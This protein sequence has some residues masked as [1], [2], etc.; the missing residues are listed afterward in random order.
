MK[1]DKPAPADF[2]SGAEP[3]PDKAGAVS[4][5]DLETEV[6]ASP[7]AEPDGDLDIAALDAEIAADGIFEADGVLEPEPAPEPQAAAEPRKTRA[8]KNEALAAV[9]EDLKAGTSVQTT[10]TA[11]PVIAERPASPAKSEPKAP[12]PPRSGRWAYGLAA[13]VSVIWV[14]L[15]GAFFSGH[16]GQ[17][18]PL[19]LEP[20]A[21]TVIGIIAAGMIAV[22]WAVAYAASQGARLAAEARTARAHDELD[23]RQRRQLR[24]ALAQAG[25][26]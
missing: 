14:A 4:E 5:T 15:I 12:P 1:R 13:F 20:V 19:N 25:G 23:R 22:F 26:A 3:S 6:D 10:E 9:V 21:L 24:G 2:S 17:V 7:E 8:K 11:A 18:E 16:F